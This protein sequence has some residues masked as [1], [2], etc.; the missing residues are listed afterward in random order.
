MIYFAAGMPRSG[1][2]LLQ[3][4]LN[5]NPT[6]Y[7]TPTSGMASTL[8]SVRKFWEQIPENVAQ[9]WVISEAQ[10]ENVLRAILYNYHTTGG[11]PHIIDKSRI[12]PSLIELIEILTSEKAKVL[13]TVRDMREILASWELL[14]RKYPTIHREI[15]NYTETVTIEQ[16]LRFYTSSNHPI[17]IAYT[18]IKDAIQRGLRD[19]LYFVRFENLT[20]QPKTT[21]MGIYEF[22]G[23]P[24]FEHDFNNIQQTVV[25]NDRVWGYPDLHTI[26]PVLTPVKSKWV[27]ILG[28]AGKNYVVNW[29]AL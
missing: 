25:E 26:R 10:K 13:V 9:D 12:W 4:I 29:D 24:Y 16:R 7:A 11:K 2:T 20:T 27:E 6:I 5:Q 17:G 23:L 15:D 1:S 21:L 19:R 22:L 3:N 28:E 18:R 14:Q 8:M